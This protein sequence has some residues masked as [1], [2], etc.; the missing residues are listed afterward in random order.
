VVALLAIEA[1]AHRQ[2]LLRLQLPRLARLRLLGRAPPR[3]LP[4]APCLVRNL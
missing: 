2:L 4:N 1:A 3:F